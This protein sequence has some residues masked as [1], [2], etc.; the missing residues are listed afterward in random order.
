MKPGIAS[1]SI[2]R[3]KGHQIEGIVKKADREDIRNHRPIRLLSALDLLEISPLYPSS[4]E[5]AVDNVESNTV[6]SALTDQGVDASYCPSLA[7]LKF[8][9]VI[10][11]DMLQREEMAKKYDHVLQIAGVPKHQRSYIRA[12][13]TRALPPHSTWNKLD[14]GDIEN[15]LLSNN[16]LLEIF[17]QLYYHDFVIFDYDFPTPQY[18]Q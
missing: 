16:T 4:A 14:R 10:R 11:Y 13:L 6:L 9:R 15:E 12:E 7:S 18:T 3:K 17:L 1:G 8:V 2:F 5:E